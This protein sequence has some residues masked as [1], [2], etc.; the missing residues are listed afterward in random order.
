VIKAELDIPELQRSL[1]KFSKMFGETNAQAVVRWSVQTCRELAFET[2]VWGKKK[3]QGKQRGAI[4]K[5]AYNVVM[6]QAKI[7]KKRR[8]KKIIRDAGELVDWINLNRVRRGARTAKLPI[9][10]RKLCSR[11]VFNKAIT[12]KTKRAGMAK[13]GFLGAGMD[14]ARRQKGQDKINI[15]KNYFGYAHKHSHFGSATKPKAGSKKPTSKITNRVSYT[16]DEYVIKKSA[17]KKA[18]KE[19]LKKTLEWYK[20]ALRRQN[21]KTK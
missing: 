6:V 21:K 10:E 14:I 9:H 13:G 17:M 1:R 16:S 11:A 4:V 12:I 3:T 2:Q 8:N 15:G 18:M 20:S 5:D 7:P 19:G